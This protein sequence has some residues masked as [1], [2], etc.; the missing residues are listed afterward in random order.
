MMTLLPRR[1]VHRTLYRPNGRQILPATISLAFMRSARHHL[2]IAVTVLGAGALST[3][4]TP[5]DDPPAPAIA[6]DAAMSEGLALLQAGN[7][8]AAADLFRAVLAGNP[9]HYGAQYQ[10]ARALDL[11]GSPDTARPE[12]E[13]A[14]VLAEQFNDAASVTTIRARLAGGDGVTDEALMARG[15]KAL[16]TDNNPAAAIAEFTAVLQRTPTHYGAHYQ[17]ATAY[18]RVNRRTE[19]RDMWRKFLV[20]AEAISDSE[21][22]ATA[23]TRIA[24]LTP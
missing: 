9:A 23:R 22:A 8:A 14:L 19:A 4:C 10:L 13:K 15:L 17:L 6:P 21:N 18:D 1:A 3:A 2:L 7:G 20:L 24:A 11:A 12:W 5:A 16:Y